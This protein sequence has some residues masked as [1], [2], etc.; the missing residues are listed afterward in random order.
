MEFMDVAVCAN[1]MQGRVLD[2]PLV[3]NALDVASLLALTGGAEGLQ[4]STTAG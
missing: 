2:Q 3:K 4:P 1:L